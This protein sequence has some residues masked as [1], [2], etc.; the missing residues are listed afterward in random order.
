MSDDRYLWERQGEP[1]PEIAS[2]ERSLGRL[3]HD[4]PLAALPAAPVPR[5]P[6]LAVLLAPRARAA[7]ALAAAAAVVVAVGIALRRPPPPASGWE[8]D[9]LAGRPE[10]AGRPL[11]G[12]GELPVG[13]WLVTG[14]DARARLE[15]ASTGLVEVEPH[16]RVR[17]VAS[18]DERQ[19]LALRRGRLTAVIWAPPGR[20][21]VET[22]SAVAVDLGCAYTLEV[23]D[24]GRGT[25]HVTSG[26]VGFAH[27]GREAFIPAGA[28]CETRP[29]AGPGTP[30]AADADPALIAGLNT[31]DF[32]RPSAARRTAVLDTVLARVRP[33]DAFTVWHLLSRTEDASR[34]RAY[35]VLSAVAPPP[36]GVTRDA[37]MRGD[38]EA[39][40]A[41]WDSLGLGETRLWRTWM[42]E[43]S[44]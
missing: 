40:D 11:E 23:D 1:D 12:R 18:A 31:L 27:R 41:W 29:G 22:P 10:V 38:R 34:A 6:W 44:R 9:A 28:R 16:S 26:W 15:L 35:D 25:V 20:F 36:P 39:L 30:H 2:L 14:A 17:L 21:V 7:F 5:R 19:Q 4:R 42:Q 33:A 8:V 37:V 43:W 13:G 3:A 24:R 32:E